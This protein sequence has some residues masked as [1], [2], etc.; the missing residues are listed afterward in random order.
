LWSTTYGLVLL[1]KLG[2]IGVMV[3]AAA[4]AQ[5]SV[6]RLDPEQDRFTHG[7]VARVLRRSVRIESAL[8]VLVLA[9]TAV[10]VSEPPGNTTYGPAVSLS[11]PLGLDTV[12]VHVDSTLRGRERFDI[13]VID[14]EGR[15]AP[16]QSITAHL[17]SVAIGALAIKLQPDTKEI[18]RGWSAWRST[19]VV[20]PD[21]G[22]WTVDLDVDID[23]IDAYATAVRY[24][25]W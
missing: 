11:A 2:L 9:V 18:G 14:A 24:Q 10:L 8:A 19:P 3:S 15:P 20:V 6:R 1:I 4:L 25:V 7:S 16:V 22:V 23:Q 12:R 5:R 13:E 17:S 21:S